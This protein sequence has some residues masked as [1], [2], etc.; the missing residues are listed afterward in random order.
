MEIFHWKEYWTRLK[1]SLRKV[2]PELTDQDLDY[3]E[4]NESELIERLSVK[5]RKSAAELNEVLFIH[6]IA[7]WDELDESGEMDE[8]QGMDPEELLEELEQEMQEPPSST[9]RWH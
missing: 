7:V 4:G 2:H 9:G 6:L 8:S 1:G 5:L 3:Q